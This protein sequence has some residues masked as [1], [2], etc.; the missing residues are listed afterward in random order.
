[1]SVGRGIAFM[2]KIIGIIVVTVALVAFYLLEQGGWHSVESDIAYVNASPILVR[3]AVSAPVQRVQQQE[4]SLVRREQP[5]LQLSSELWEQSFS[6]TKAQLESFEVKRKSIETL[7]AMMP[8]Q[9]EADK[10]AIKLQQEAQKK[11]E[12]A[13]ERLKTWSGSQSAHE[14]ESAFLRYAEQSVALQSAQQQS[15][16]SEKEWISLQSELSQ[17]RLSIESA[18]VS[19]QTLQRLSAY[20]QLTAPKD[21]ILVKYHVQPGEHVQPGQLLATLSPKDSQWLDVYF[22]ETVLSKLSV[23]SSVRVVFDAYPDQPIKGEIL[24][25]S[26]LAGAALSGTTPNYTAGNFTRVVQ[27]IPVRVSFDASALPHVAVG[28]SAT[29]TVTP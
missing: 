4:G 3:S 2:K 16:R 21:A 11:A 13:W 22:K 14:I 24:S 9:R 5:L 26:S 18:K 23:G 7:L 6:E 15:I 29:V 12:S 28:M 20:Y 8:M 10:E 25:V 19:L 1:M 17:L 27:K